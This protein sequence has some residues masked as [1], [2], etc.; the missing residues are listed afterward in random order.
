L[1]LYWR[2]TS[3]NS[4]QEKFVGFTV[5]AIQGK[6]SLDS[7]LGSKPLPLVVYPGSA[8]APTSANSLVDLF[9]IVV[10]GAEEHSTL[11]TVEAATLL[12]VLVLLV[13]GGRM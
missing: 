11:Q 6:A 2:T 7:W 3:E 8:L 1:E 12:S 9:A 13:G 10:Q 4:V 5:L